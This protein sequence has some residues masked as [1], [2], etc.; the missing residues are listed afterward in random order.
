MNTAYI[1]LIP[2]SNKDHTQCSNYRPISLIN[3]DLKIII[4]AVTGRLES[5]MSTRDD[6]L[7]IDLEC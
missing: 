2:K 4:K 3:V 6:N 1:S 7:I 5:V